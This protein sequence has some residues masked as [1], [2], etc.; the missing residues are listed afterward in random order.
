LG[1][2]HLSR[3]VGFEK[4]VERVE[5]RRPMKAPAE[6]SFHCFQRKDHIMSKITRSRQACDDQSIVIFLPFQEN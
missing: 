1:E 6:F 2:E 3:D 4:R 5:N